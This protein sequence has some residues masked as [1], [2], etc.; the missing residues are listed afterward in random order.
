[1]HHKLTSSRDVGLILQRRLEWQDE[2]K[3]KQWTLDSFIDEVRVNLS[4]NLFNRWS[5][6]IFFLRANRMT[7]KRWSKTFLG[8]H[9]PKITQS[10]SCHPRLIS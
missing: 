10:L 1:M 6:E 3:S 5:L 4:L 7:R 2:E 9:P 8:P